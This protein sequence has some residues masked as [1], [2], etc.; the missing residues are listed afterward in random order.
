MYVNSQK[1]QPQFG[2][3]GNKLNFYEI[4][5]I[6]EKPESLDYIGE[7]QYFGKLTTNPQALKRTQ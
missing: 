7:G 3:L 2:F 1:S 6:S 4:G 5:L